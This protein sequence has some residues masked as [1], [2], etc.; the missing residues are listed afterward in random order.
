MT[1]TSSGGQSAPDDRADWEI[2][3]ASAAAP[4][5]GRRGDAAPAARARRAAARFPY[6]HTQRHVA[7]PVRRDGHDPAGIPGDCTRAA[8]ATLL[9]EPDD[10]AVPHSVLASEGRWWATMRLWTIERHGLDWQIAWQTPAAGSGAVTVELEPWGTYWAER[11][12]GVLLSGRSPR[13]PFLHLCVGDLDGTVL[14][15]P[16]PSRAGLLEVTAAYVPV[17]ALLTLPWHPHRLALPAGVA[18]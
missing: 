3:G 11:A 8:I 7:C 12:R 2:V 14:W 15:D 9:G 6:R 16:H 5:I 10:L 1:Q 18:A 4:G 13:G 17:D